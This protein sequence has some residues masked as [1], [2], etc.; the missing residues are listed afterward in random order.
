MYLLHAPGGNIIY[1]FITCSWRKYYLCIYYMLLE[2]IL[3]MYLLH[4]PG[5]NIIYVFITL[6]EDVMNT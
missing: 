6:E 5:G 3:C 2:E 4:A 1:V